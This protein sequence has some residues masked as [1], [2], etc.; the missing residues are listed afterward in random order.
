MSVDVISCAIAVVASVGCLYSQAVTSPEA[1]D[2][3]VTT[4]SCGSYQ[5]FSSRSACR[6]VSEVKREADDVSKSSASSHRSSRNLGTTPPNQGL[7]GL[8]PRP[9]GQTLVT[10]ARLQDRPSEPQDPGAFLVRQSPPSPCT[11]G[12]GR[13]Q[14]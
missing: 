6:A 14:N 2:P 5:G 9:V 13:R 3:S 10:T 7:S 12:N 11:P 8:R 4:A 1:L